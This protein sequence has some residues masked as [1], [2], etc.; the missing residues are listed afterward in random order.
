M[1]LREFT[2]IRH[3][4]ANIEAKTHDDYDHLSTKG[5][6]Q[7]ELL[8]RYIKNSARYGAVVS[9]DLRRQRNTAKIAN[10]RA[11]DHHIDPRLN[12]LDYYGLGHSLEKRR[13]IAMPQSEGA[14]VPFMRNILRDWEMDEMCPDLETYA[15]FRT[16][17]RDAVTTLATQYDRPLLFSSGGVISTLAHLAM[18]GDHDI[19]IGFMLRV[20][21][22]SMHR[23]LIDTETGALQLRQ[24]GATPHFE[25]ENDDWI[26]FV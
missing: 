5:E 4:Q 21:H 9:G 2:I 20:S 13:G 10:T 26:T 16:R 12:E 19:K 25:N 17:V 14:F 3:G 22:T 8:G 23:F 24:F 18:G 6:A 7:A 11:L 15:Q 1:A